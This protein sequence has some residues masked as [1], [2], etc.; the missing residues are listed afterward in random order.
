MGELMSVAQRGPAWPAAQ[1]RHTRDAGQGRIFSNYARNKLVLVP[2]HAELLRG[3]RK[4]GELNTKLHRR[5]RGG[6]RPGSRAGS[7]DKHHFK[8]DREWDL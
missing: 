3:A 7:L 1:Q 8:E 2:V 5:G 6:G 4:G